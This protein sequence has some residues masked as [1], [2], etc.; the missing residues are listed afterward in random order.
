MG[1][2]QDDHAEKDREE[3]QRG[4]G[5]AE[6]DREESQRGSGQ[7]APACLPAVVRLTR[8]FLDDDRNCTENANLQFVLRQLGV[9]SPATHCHSRAAA[10][11]NERTRCREACRS[12]AAVPSAGAPRSQRQF[13]LR[14]NRGREAR[15]SAG[16]VPGAAAPQSQWHLHY[17]KWEEGVR[18]ISAGHTINHRTTHAIVRSCSYTTCDNSPP[19]KN[20]HT[21]THTHT[22]T[23]AA[24]SFT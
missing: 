7:D 11:W 24:D 3:S 20:Q 2:W 10:L 18:C 1:G 5:H 19:H 12:A 4:S 23:H 6:K 21:H 17:S 22:H 8:G 13:K 14:S 15:R 16:A 9:D